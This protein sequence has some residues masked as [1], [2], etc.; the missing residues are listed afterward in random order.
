MLLVMNFQYPRNEFYHVVSRFKF[1]IFVH[2]ATP[3]G[4]KSR[5]PQEFS[6]GY[7]GVVFQMVVTRGIIHPM[8]HVLKRIKHEDYALWVKKNHD[9]IMKSCL[10]STII[11]IFLK[12]YSIVGSS[13]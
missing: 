10:I 7:T 2:G 6:Y 5:I 3:Y 9:R 13:W 1:Y 4:I 12:F 11:W 8:L